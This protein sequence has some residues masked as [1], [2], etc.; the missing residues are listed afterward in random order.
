MRVKVLL[1]GCAM[2]VA[3]AF[4]TTA[5]AQVPAGN[6]YVCH[7]VKDEKVPAKFLAQT[8]AKVD[9]VAA[10]SLDLKK[11]FL[12][13]NPAAPAVD[14]TLH[15]VCYKAKGGKFAASF[16]TTDQFGPLRLSTKK[17]FLFCT[18]ASKAPA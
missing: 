3:V 1:T 16:D 10:H 17:P 6:Q 7:K 5:S 18:P 15:Y 12:L 13:C 9:Q 8:I 2:A 4:A 14:P 11:A